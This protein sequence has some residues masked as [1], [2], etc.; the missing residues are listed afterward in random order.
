MNTTKTKS[1][2]I[3]ICSEFFFGLDHTKYLSSRN[4]LSAFSLHPEPCFFSFKI[5]VYTNFFKRQISGFLTVYE[6]SKLQCFGRSKITKTCWQKNPKDFFIKY[7]KLVH[8]SYC[9]CS[10][11]LKFL[12]VCRTRISLTHSLTAIGNSIVACPLRSH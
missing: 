5:L 11:A 2:K 9:S 10:T 8:A 6:D 4:F 7:N 1:T 12:H 3:K